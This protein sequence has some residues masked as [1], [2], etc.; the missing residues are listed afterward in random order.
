MMHKYG[1]LAVTTLSTLMAAIDSTIVYLAL[2]AMGETFHSGISYL[3]IVV[4][5]YLISTTVMLVPAIEITKRI[6]NRNFYIIG[7]SRL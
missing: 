6:G 5:A 7:F 4:S 1:V 2:P 3:T